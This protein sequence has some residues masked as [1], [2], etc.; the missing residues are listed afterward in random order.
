MDDETFLDDPETIAA[1]QDAAEAAELEA[2]EQAGVEA[3]EAA[4]DEG[5]VEAELEALRAERDELK[6]RLLRALAETE[7]LRKRADRDRRDAE[8]YGGVRLA[9]D[10]LS[11]HD[12]L[13]RAL[14]AIDDDLRAH[15][16]PVVEGIELTQKDLLAAFQK[17]KIEKIEP[18]P[19]DKFD[20]KL[21]EAMFEAPVPDVAQGCV[22]QVMATGFVIGD[23]L[24]RPAKVGVS[25][26]APA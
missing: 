20:P 23:R 24:L 9:R 22:I 14:E 21:H 26:G 4:R 8:L 10:L 3:A 6:D 15:A 17:H 25:S 18:Q 1:E 16:G 11:V 19:G 7:N 12:N 2:A 5:P 13:G